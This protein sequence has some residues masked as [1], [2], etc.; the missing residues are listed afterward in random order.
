MIQQIEL[1][2]LIF[3]ILKVCYYSTLTLKQNEYNF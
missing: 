1:D 2:S 3:F